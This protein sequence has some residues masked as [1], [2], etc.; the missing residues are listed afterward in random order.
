MLLALATSVYISLPVE[1]LLSLF[2]PL[3]DPAAPYIV[4]PLHVAHPAASVTPPAPASPPEAGPSLSFDDDEDPF[5]ASASSHGSSFRPGNGHALAE[6]GM[7]NR[8]LSSAS[9]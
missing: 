3:F 8:F 4:I 5:E 6:P 2:Y 9:G 1:I 7:T